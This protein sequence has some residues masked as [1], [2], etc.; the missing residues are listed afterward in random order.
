MRAFFCAKNIK[1]VRACGGCCTI[2]ASASERGPQ[3]TATVLSP[4]EELVECHPL[5]AESLNQCSLRS[6]CPGRSLF[7]DPVVDQEIRLPLLA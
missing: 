6:R 7:R 5:V 4:A 1:S 3:P 2:A